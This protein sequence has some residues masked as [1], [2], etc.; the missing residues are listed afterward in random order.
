MDILFGASIIASFLAGM[1]ALFAPCCITV[2]LPSYLASVFRERTAILK[3]TL[4][5]F[6]GI[7]LV[8]V[9][10][11]LGAAVLAQ[12]FQRFHR[13]MY[14]VGGSLMILFGAMSWQ[15]KG[16]A[17]FPFLP[18]AQ[19]SRH[20]SAQSVFLLGIFSGAATSCCAPVLAGAV[21][22]AVVSGTFWKAL[23]VVFAYVFGMTFP[24]FV[25][26]QAYDTLHIERTAFAK[27]RGPAI[28]A[29][30][31]FFATGSVLLYLAFMGDVFFAPSYQAS[32][33]RMFTRWSFVLV[34]RM[35]VV[36]NVVWGG[37]ILLLFA[38]FTIMA[39]RRKMD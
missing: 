7:A 17:M 16:F 23:V 20:N 29:S 33:G 26:A 36:P 4:V 6:S 35:S 18:K 21:T 15:G 2:L 32:L 28:V 1:A 27:G 22:L 13:E 11:G 25:A 30:S 31:L 19:T 9:P 38:F 37:A 5:F 3:M 8:L 24:L 39:R 10:I 14:I 34:E 12:V